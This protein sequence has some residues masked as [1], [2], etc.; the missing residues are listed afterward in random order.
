MALQEVQMAWLARV[1]ASHLHHLAPMR[2]TMFD[3][4]AGPLGA[5]AQRARLG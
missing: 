5:C 4:T 3:S 2:Q 1:P